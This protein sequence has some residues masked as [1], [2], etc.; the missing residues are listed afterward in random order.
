MRWQVA[1]V[2]VSTVFFLGN[3][4]AAKGF[5]VERYS[6]ILLFSLVGAFSSYRNSSA[7]AKANTKHSSKQHKVNKA[8][9]KNVSN[10]QQS[11]QQTNKQQSTQDRHFRRHTDQAHKA[12]CYLLHAA[13]LFLSAVFVFEGG[14]PIIACSANKPIA[15]LAV[16]SQ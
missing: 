2:L 6:S 12:D 4:T 9:Q 5:G 14:H 15:K 16:L 10:K 13:L 1:L 3:K 7:A 8:K 11:K